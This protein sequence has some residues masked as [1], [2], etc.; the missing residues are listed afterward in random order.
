M[1]TASRYD[2]ALRDASRSALGSSYSGLF[3]RVL[4]RAVERG[5]IPGDAD[6]ET[7]GEIFPAVAYQRVAAR[8]QLDDLGL[9]LDLDPASEEVVG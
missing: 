1:I 6:V 4:S 5:E 3:E 8:G 7:I 2:S 9:A